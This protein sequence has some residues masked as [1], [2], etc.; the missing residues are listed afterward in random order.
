MPNTTNFNWATP[1]DTDLVK[2]GAAAIRTLGNSIDSSFVDLKGGTTGQVLTKASNTDLD[3]SF[4][5]PTDQTPLTTKGDLFTFTT[6]DARLGVGTNG[7]ILTADSAETTGL[8]WAA[9]PASGLTLIT[10]QSFSS[11]ASVNVNDVFSTTYENYLVFLNGTVSGGSDMNFRFRVAGADD[12]TSNYF[13]QYNDIQ[14]TTN[15]VARQ[16]SQNVSRFGNCDANQRFAS[17]IIFY[18]PFEA[19][20]KFV[21]AVITRGST[22]S[23]IAMGRVLT[24][25]DAATS[26]T[27]F[28]ILPTGGNITGSVK[29]YGYKK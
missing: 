19:E 24:G 13:I 8:K 29:I 12:S 4:T 16:T 25:F 7:H 20:K 1:A 11:A 3:F 26:F 17:N 27:G 5:T 18:Q 28:S 2:D 14:S 23:A 10:N 9:A 6:V 21:D 22:G 15:N